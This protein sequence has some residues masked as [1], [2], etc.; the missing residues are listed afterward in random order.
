MTVLAG[1]CVGPRLRETKFLSLRETTFLLGMCVGSSSQ[2]DAIF[3]LVKVVL[4][5]VISER[6]LFDVNL[7]HW[8]W[9]RLKEMTCRMV[10]M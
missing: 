8:A 6:R 9:C 5:Y 10:K 2:R 1:I 3:S 7:L 4:N